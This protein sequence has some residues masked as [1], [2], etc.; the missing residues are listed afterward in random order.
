M[1]KF[2]VLLSA[3]SIAAVSFGQVKGEMSV[4]GKLGITAGSLTGSTTVSVGNNASTEKNN[5]FSNVNFI[6][7]P[8]FN[9]FVIDNLQITGRLAYGVSSVG[10]R[11]IEDNN[12]RNRVN[13]HSFMIGPAVSYYLKLAD[14]FY[15]TPEF[16]IYAS[17]YVEESITKAAGEK[18]IVKSPA[19]GG[20][21]LQFHLAS[22]EYR[23]TPGLGISMNLLSMDVNCLT[24]TETE[25]VAG[26]EVKAKTNKTDF[27]FNFG[28]G[29]TVGVKYYF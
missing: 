27:N 29:I 18:N 13:T 10:I 25:T 6:I 14:N 11:D 12:Y 20:A 15:Y 4:G 26:M 8:E 3:M 28:A 16:G 7:A 9:Y 17:V 24:A 21:D 1:K 19:F 2:F 23:P 22:F 5:P